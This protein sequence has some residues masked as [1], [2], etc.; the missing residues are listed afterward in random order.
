[1]GETT[2]ARAEREKDRA[3]QL[4]KKIDSL[5]EELRRAQKRAETVMQDLVVMIKDFMNKKPEFGK[6]SSQEKF[7]PDGA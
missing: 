6:I 4:Q 5:E 3:D 2:H 1:M 7:I